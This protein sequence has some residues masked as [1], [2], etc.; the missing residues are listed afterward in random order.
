MKSIKLVRID[1]ALNESLEGEPTQFE[2]LY[3]C[4]LGSVAELTRQVVDQTLANVPDGGEGSPWGGYLAIDESTQSVIGT[5]AFKAPPSEDSTVEIAYYT[6]PEYE[7]QGY[8]T[9]MAG[10]LIDLAK[11]ATEVRRII[12][13][14]LPERNAS[15]KVL[16]K[17]GMHFAG[18]VFEPEDGTLWEWEL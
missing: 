16:G 10:M 9:A 14:T 5:C 13:R 4:K 1:H 3:Q 2:A 8:A 7:G 18:E 15:T 12:A 17:V 6:F 11:A